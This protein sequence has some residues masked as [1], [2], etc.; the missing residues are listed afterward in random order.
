MAEWI[1]T[2]DS[3]G[4]TPE[5]VW[6]FN[7]TQHEASAALVS[8]SEERAESLRVWKLEGHTVLNVDATVVAD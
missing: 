8:K 2:T 5:T 1:I 4:S 3:N 6:M 7:G